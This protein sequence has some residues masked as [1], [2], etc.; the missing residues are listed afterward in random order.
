MDGMGL[1]SEWE[2]VFG[3]VTGVTILRV[4]RGEIEWPG[5]GI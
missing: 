2:L 5:D 3:G 1:K 4:S